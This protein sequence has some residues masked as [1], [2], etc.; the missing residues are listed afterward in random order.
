MRNRVV[1]RGCWEILRSFNISAL[2][3]SICA[4]YCKE[5]FSGSFLIMGNVKGNQDEGHS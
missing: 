3:V 4:I 1:I 5:K 2:N